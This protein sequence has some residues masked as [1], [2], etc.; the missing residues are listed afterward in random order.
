VHSKCGEHCEAW[1]GF[2]AMANSV[3]LFNLPWPTLVTMVTRYGWR[4]G[5]KKL[6]AQ[7]FQGWSHVSFIRRHET[8]GRKQNN[9]FVSCN[10]TFIHFFLNVQGSLL[11]SRDQTYACRDCAAVCARRNW[12]RTTANERASTPR[13]CDDWVYGHVSDK[14]TNLRFSEG[15]AH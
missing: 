10:L 1:H 15:L 11:V 12:L 14:P 3:A 2:S 4:R 5:Q 8:L 7:N 6:T 13:A 9:V